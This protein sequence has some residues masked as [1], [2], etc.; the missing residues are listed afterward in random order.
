V[1]RKLKFKG[2]TLKIE[3][4]QP[5]PII[6][7]SISLPPQNTISVDLINREPDNSKPKV[8]KMTRILNNKK[9]DMVQED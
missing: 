6:H 7:R 3:M 9:S 2:K 5:I 1:G 4:P 8:S